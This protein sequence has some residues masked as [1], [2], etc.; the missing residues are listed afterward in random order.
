MGESASTSVLEVPRTAPVDAPGEQLWWS[1]R[2][3]GIW[4]ELAGPSHLISLLPAD[5][6]GE[7]LSVRRAPR[8]PGRYV[9][10]VDRKSVV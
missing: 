1:R 6:S 10:V 7:Y 5:A 2:D 9:Q 4:H 3:T 8:H